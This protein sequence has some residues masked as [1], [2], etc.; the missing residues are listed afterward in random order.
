MLPIIFSMFPGI[1][2]VSYGRFMA[3]R[4]KLIYQRIF[5]TVADR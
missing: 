1:A 4:C 2:G 3:M 5:R